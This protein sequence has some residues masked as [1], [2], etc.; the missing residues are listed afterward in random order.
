MESA[1]FLNRDCMILTG[2]RHR[3]TEFRRIRATGR[4]RQRIVYCIS[5][6]G[7]GRFLF[8]EVT[9]VLDGVSVGWYDAVYLYTVLFVYTQVVSLV[10]SS[11]RYSAG[12]LGSFGTAYSRSDYTWVGPQSQVS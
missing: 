8:R 7:T 12:W 1:R 10:K 9:L 5:I 4:C 2:T 11:K 3:V 6:T